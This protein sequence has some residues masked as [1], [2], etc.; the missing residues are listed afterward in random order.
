MLPKKVFFAKIDI[1]FTL[2]RFHLFSEW[3]S[4]YMCINVGN[5]EV[6]DVKLENTAQVLSIFFRLGHIRNQQW[7]GTGHC[8][9]M[10]AV[11]S[12]EALQS[13][14]SRSLSQKVRERASIFFSSQNSW[15]SETQC[16]M[17]WL[18]H[19]NLNQDLWSINMWHKGLIKNVFLL[20]PTQDSASHFPV[21]LQSQKLPDAA[22][23]G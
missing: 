16:K 22:P 1:R 15:F 5:W 9:P 11:C 23:Q 18:R 8:Y 12:T 17:R 13:S 3:V 10:S 2:M 6:Y 7:W 21:H 4:N 19:V 20:Q 14:Q